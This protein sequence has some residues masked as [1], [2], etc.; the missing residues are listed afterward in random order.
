M[1]N[2]R[3][4]PSQSLAATSY[5]SD[6]RLSSRTVAECRRSHRRRDTPLLARQH[7]VAPANQGICKGWI[8]ISIYEHLSTV[9]Q[10]CSVIR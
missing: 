8:H 5:C 6:R 4:L 2:T 7:G 9:K 1:T 3:M 10:N